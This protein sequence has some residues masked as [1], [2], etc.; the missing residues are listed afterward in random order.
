MDQPLRPLRDDEIRAFQEDGV[1]AARGLFPAPWLERMAKA[2]DRVV[3]S[4]GL[5]GSQVSMQN[6]GFSGD[7]FVW[8]WDDDF[9]DWIYDSPAALI[10]RQVLPG[11]SIRHFYDQLFVKPAGCQVPTPW[12]STSTGQKVT[13]WC[14][15]V[16]TWQPGGFTKS[17]S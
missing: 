11:P 3:A 1:V 8:K 9:R 12:H 5:F 14:Q 15:G 7:L 2:V 6:E 13:S 4:P 17:W 10:A 16:G